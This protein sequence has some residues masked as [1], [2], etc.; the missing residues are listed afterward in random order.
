MTELECM[1]NYSLVPVSS[2]NPWTV[3]NS[4]DIS[5]SAV[6][7]NDIQHESAWTI[8]INIP[9]EISRDYTNENDI[10]DIQVEWY[11]VDSD[12][13][14]SII[15][16]QNSVPSSDDFNLIISDVLPY[17]VPWIFIILFIYFVFRFIKKVF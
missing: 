3:L 17:F 5:W 14:E 10:L 13:I 6:F 12:Y 7:I 1:T 2:E 8:N 16:T 15:D 4:W 11:N 9:S